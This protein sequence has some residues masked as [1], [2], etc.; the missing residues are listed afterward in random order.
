[1]NTKH[2]FTNGFSKQFRWLIGSAA[3]FSACVVMAP[4]TAN[5]NENALEEKA[6][7]TQHIEE[8]KSLINSNF[9]NASIIEQI[10]HNNNASVAQS[11]SGDFQMRNFAFIY[12]NGNNNTGNISQQGSN[13]TGTI[14]Q[15]GSNNSATI[16]QEGNHHNASINQKNNDGLAFSADIRQFGSSSDVHIVQP[17]ENGWRSISIEHHAYSADALPVFV[18]T[19]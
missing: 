5:E 18:E 13:N 14:S 9:S 11:F 1:M 19:H 6:K 2:I 4:A 3:L 10:G 17:S 15:Q 16:W 7:I 12:Q 8:Q